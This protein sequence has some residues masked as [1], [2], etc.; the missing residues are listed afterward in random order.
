MEYK[1]LSSKYEE[2]LIEDINRYVS[3]GWDVVGSMV[4]HDGKLVILIS[5]K[6]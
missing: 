4:V 6:I 3:E 2:V 1:I 5:R